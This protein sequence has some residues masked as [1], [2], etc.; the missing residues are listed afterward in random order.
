[1]RNIKKTK[2]DPQEGLKQAGKGMHKTNSSYSAYHSELDKLKSLFDEYT[3]HTDPC[4]LEALKTSYPDNDSNHNE[5]YNL[6]DS[7]RGFLQ[8]L[9]KELFEQDS[10]LIYCPL[11]NHNV[12][13]DLDHYIPRA[14]MPEYSIHLYNLIPICHQCNLDKGDSWLGSDGKRLFFNAYFDNA[15]DMADVLDCQITIDE[16]SK[17]P[18]VCLTL[19]PIS[20]DDSESVRLAKSTTEKLEL[21]KKY[22]QPKAEQTLNGICKQ[23]VN[24]YRVIK[25]KP[26][27]E[28]HYEQQIMVLKMSIED[29]SSVEAIPNIVRKTVMTSQL[30]TL[31]MIV[32]LEKLEED[33]LISC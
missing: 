3:N 25:K 26:S 13:L 2:T 22:W 31:W 17:N 23:F 4:T 15:P 29:S 19:K 10:N 5:L 12:V 11:C 30:F 33:K 20:E 16:N 18:K 14:K 21:I 1:M 27:F 32:E 28:D 24:Q 7:K 9:R 8:H 6:Y